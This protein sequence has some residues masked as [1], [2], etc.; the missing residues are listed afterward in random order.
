MHENISGRFSQFDYTFFSP[1]TFIAIECQT[2]SHS[3]FA[4][5][6]TTSSTIDTAVIAIAIARAVYFF[7]L[8]LMWLGAFGEIQ[9]FSFYFP[10][11]FFLVIAKFDHVTY[12]QIPFDLI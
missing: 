2:L 11:F 7:L 4:A 5:A 8:D 1:V 10:I 9:Y 3:I 6:T 12:T